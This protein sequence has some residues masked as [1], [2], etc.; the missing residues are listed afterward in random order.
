MIN[1]F[2]GRLN[3]INGFSEI[4]FL[5]FTK[6]L[7]SPILKSPELYKKINI[8]LNQYVLKNFIRDK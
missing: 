8:P 1:Y 3:Y 5:M 7:R 6:N 4:F 2:R